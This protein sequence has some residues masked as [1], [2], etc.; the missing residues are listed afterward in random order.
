MHTRQPIHRPM[1][2]RAAPPVDGYCGGVD[3]SNPLR[4]LAPTTAPRRCG[5]AAA[6]VAAVAATLT[7]AGISAPPKLH[8]PALVAADNSCAVPEPAPSAELAATVA[9]PSATVVAYPRAA[10]PVLNA[11]AQRITADA[12]DPVSGRFDVVRLRAWH[13]DNGEQTTRDVVRWYHD[14]DSGAALTSEY[15]DPWPG[16]THDFWPPGW[17]SHRNLS[18]AFIS[19]DFFRYNAGLHTSDLDGDGRLV[20][21]LAALATWHSPAPSGRALA[22]TE[23]AHTPGLVAYPR[24]VDRA[25]RTGIG[26]ATTT[27]GDAIQRHLLILHPSTGQVLAYERATR[28]PSGWQPSAYLLLLTRTH[29]E[30]RWWEP[31]TTADALETAQPAN[32]MMPRQQGRHVVHA[33]QPCT[34]EPPTAQ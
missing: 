17:L 7:L 18:K 14:D 1:R 10:R 2:H 33:H 31:P 30:R 26:V 20:T 21:G 22:V 23:L 19:G 6:G 28:T 3:T 16:V 11:L 24:T 8:M 9:A 34:P 4:R 25:G 5:V 12:C 13:L 27:N 32:L 29:T 15:P